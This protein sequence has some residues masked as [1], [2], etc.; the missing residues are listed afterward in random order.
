VIG[1]VFHAGRDIDL[2]DIPGSQ[3]LQD[4]PAAVDVCLDAL[5]LADRA[6]PC[7]RDG[8][9]R[10]PSI[11][12]RRISIAS[13]ERAIATIGGPSILKRRA[14]AVC[15]PVAAL[16]ILT[17]ALEWALAAMGREWTLAARQ[18]LV[19]W[20]VPSTTLAVGRPLTA[21]ESLAALAKA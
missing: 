13:T 20:A 19:E 15:P 7:S 16:A 8:A 6:T 10:S 12:K 18:V 4:G 1:G 5:E 3:R 2:D 21:A 11:G 17:P 14:I 9:Q